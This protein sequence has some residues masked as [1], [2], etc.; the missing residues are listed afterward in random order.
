M[1]SSYRTDLNMGR[2]KEWEEKLRQAVTL[3]KEVKK[4]VAE[5]SDGEGQYDNMYDD[6]VLAGKLA[7]AIS[8]IEFELPL[9][10]E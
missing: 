3:I 1:S 5:F 8:V 7:V 6:G 4:E 2:M 9:P 10:K